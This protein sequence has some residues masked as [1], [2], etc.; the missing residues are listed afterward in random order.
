MERR[1]DGPDQGGGDLAHRLRLGHQGLGCPCRVGGQGRVEGLPGSH[2]AIIQEEVEATK[3]ECLRA[4]WLWSHLSPAAIP[5]M[6]SQ[7]REGGWG[8]GDAPPFSKKQRTQ[9]LGIWRRQ[10]SPEDSDSQS[11]GGR[12]LFGGAHRMPGTVVTLMALS[13]A[14]SPEGHTLGPGRARTHTQS[15]HI[16]GERSAGTQARRGLLSAQL[17][18]WLPSAQRRSQSPHSGHSAH[19]LPQGLCTRWPHCPGC[20]SPVTC[21]AHSLS[22]RSLLRNHLLQEAFLGHR[23]VTCSQTAATSYLKYATQ[24]PGVS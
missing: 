13:A 12:W 6:R 24:N 8:S 9:T 7:R 20:S 10:V 3:S 5:R 14:T 21:L 18:T 19:V 22:S 23:D 1:G 4:A 17:P 11:S 2:P 15:S 16:D